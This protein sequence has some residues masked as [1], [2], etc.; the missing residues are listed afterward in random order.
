MNV[1]ILPSWYPHSKSPL[2]GVFVKEQAQAYAEL[3][4]ED[5]VVIGKWNNGYCEVTPRKPCRN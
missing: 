2:G 3:N 1:L 4:P 5:N